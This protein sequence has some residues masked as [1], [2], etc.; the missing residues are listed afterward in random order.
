MLC[1][2]ARRGECLDKAVAESFFG[3]LKTELTDD[4]DYRTRAQ[5]RQ[6]IFDY[7]EI[8]YNRRRRHSF[9]EYR[10]PWEFE[11]RLVANL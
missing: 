7:I 5:A 9:I 10:T 2:R 1:S 6:S 8:F 3:T 4:E 11:Q